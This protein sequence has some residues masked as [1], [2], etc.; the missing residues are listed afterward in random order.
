MIGGIKPLCSK[1]YSWLIV[2]QTLAKPIAEERLHEA[3]KNA[4]YFLILGIICGCVTFLANY[5]FTVAGE[6]LTKRLRIAIFANIINQVLHLFC[7][8]FW[9][10]RLNTIKKTE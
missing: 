4:M 5:L 1:F 6:L 8:I 3:F 2:L 9:K 10:K 7:C